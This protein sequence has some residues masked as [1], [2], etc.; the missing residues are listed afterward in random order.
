MSYPFVVVELQQR[1]PKN[2]FVIDDACLTPLRQCVQSIFV[3]HMDKIERVN[4]ILKVS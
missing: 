1:Y 2:P 3:Q 4:F